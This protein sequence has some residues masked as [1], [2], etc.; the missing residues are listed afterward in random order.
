MIGGCAGGWPYGSTIC[1]CGQHSNVHPCSSPP[2]SLVDGVVPT[3]V[4]SDCHSWVFYTSL[5]CCYPYL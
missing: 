2:F 1:V 5:S 4:A 3:I